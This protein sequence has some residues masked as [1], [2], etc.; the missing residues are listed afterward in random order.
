[1]G[2]QKIYFSSNTG[3]F[4]QSNETC[5]WEVK[6]YY[7][8]STA[9]I[10][11]WPFHRSFKTFLTMSILS[12]C[13]DAHK[14]CFVGSAAPDRLAISCIPIEHIQCKTSQ[15]QLFWSHFTHLRFPWADRTDDSIKKSRKWRLK[16][17]DQ[18]HWCKVGASNRWTTTENTNNTDRKCII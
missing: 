11:V 13:Q 9:L 15:C 14:A 6:H 1:M 2:T 17:E 16:K 5:K 12:G 3:F 10:H 7:P 18:Q 4:S 8:V